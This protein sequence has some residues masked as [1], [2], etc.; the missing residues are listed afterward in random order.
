ML[1][2]VAVIAVWG[3]AAL[4]LAREFGMDIGPILAGAGILGLAVGFG[5]Q[6]LVKDFFSG[7]FLLVEDQVRI[8]DVVEAGGKSGLVEKVTLR[9]TTL[10]G[11]DGTLHVVPNGEIQTV[12]NHTYGWSRALIDIGVSYYEDIDRVYGI[13]RDVAAEMRKDEQFKDWILEDI[14]ILGVDEFADS[15]IVIKVLIR[16]QPIRQW[17]V[18]R[19]YRRRLKIAFDRED[20]EI[21]FPHRTVY[22]RVEE[23]LSVLALEKPSNGRWKKRRW[24]TDGAKAAARQA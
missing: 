14:E 17:A 15:A 4:M 19:D 22:H 10:R 24:S 13:I 8:G 20:I 5:A 1:N 11:L 9:T 3:I 12:S 16:T 18:A 23:P 7:F 6:S 2:T 21:P